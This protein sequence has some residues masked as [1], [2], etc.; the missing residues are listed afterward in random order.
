[1]ED[2][3]FSAVL[4]ETL[5]LFEVTRSIPVLLGSVMFDIKS[6][7]EMLGDSE[8]E[9]WRC[10]AVRPVGVG[11]AMCAVLDKADRVACFRTLAS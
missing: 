9:T 8:K 3:S 6:E 5:P 4:V 10:L 1:M 2:L 7:V 11:V